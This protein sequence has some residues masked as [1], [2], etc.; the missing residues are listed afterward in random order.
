MTTDFRVT[1]ASAE[2]WAEFIVLAQRSY[3]QEI[4]D[5][6]QLREVADCR[7]AIRSE[8][9]IAGGVGI[10]TGQF[11]GGQE[12][13]C[14]LLAGGC[15]AP[16]ERGNRLAGELLLG[17]LGPLADAGAVVVSAWTT[18]NEYGRKIGWQAPCAVHSWRVR[19]DDLR[20]G[21]PG[22]GHRVSFGISDG[23][24]SLISEVA[25]RWNGAIRRPPWWTDWK[26]RQMGLGIYEFRDDTGAVRGVTAVSGVSKQPVKELRVHDFIAGDR[27]VASSMFD[28][29]SR[30]NSLAEWVAFRRASL[31]PAPLL[32]HNLSRV[33]AQ[34]ES[35]HPWMLRILDIE[36]ALQQRGWRESASSAFTMEAVDNF[37]DTVHRFDL[38]VDKGVSHVSKSTRKPD[39]TLDLCQLATWYAGGYRSAESAL[40]DGISSHMSSPQHGLEDFVSLT[41]AQEI[42]LPE[43]F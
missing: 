13:R 7:V 38:E 6:E 14:G 4:N 8:T 28:F 34:A 10:V 31:P 19:A 11:F 1:T 24:E 20:R 18:S 21:F 29:L 3:G 5:A 26:T 41:N 43:Q 15:I 33:R 12:V 39:F 37:T 27:A 35:H 9:V 32:L 36:G 30:Y 23:G 40:L 2:Q 17:R 25:Q 22:S 16:E 42:W